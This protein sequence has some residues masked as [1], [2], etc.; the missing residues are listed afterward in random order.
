MLVA[1]DNSVKKSGSGPGQAG[2][3]PFVGFDLADTIRRR[4]PR[5]RVFCEG[6]LEPPSWEA[7]CLVEVLA[8]G[9]IFFRA[10]SGC[11]AIWTFQL[12]LDAPDSEA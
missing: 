2:S 10:F 8:L 11:P 6:G 12:I 7:I 9:V 5:P 1:A 3:P 4:V